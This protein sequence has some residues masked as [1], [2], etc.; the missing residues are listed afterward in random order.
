[1]H[2]AMRMQLLCNIPI[3]TVFCDSS[4]SVFACREDMKPGRQQPHLQLLAAGSA[5][6]S[7]AFGF[8]NSKTGKD[9]GAPTVA[10]I[11]V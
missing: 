6:C 11:S 4:A 2:S 3:H 9:P 5:C 10:S 8:A 1:M 7:T